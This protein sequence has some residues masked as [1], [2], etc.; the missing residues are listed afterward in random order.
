M[1]NPENEV[2]VKP[3]K[4]WNLLFG[5]YLLSLGFILVLMQYLVSGTQVLQTPHWLFNIGLAATLL[6]GY[7]VMRHYARPSAELARNPQ[8]A[9]TPLA[10]LCSI[11]ELPGILGA[12]MI[13]FALSPLEGGILMTASLLLMLLLRPRAG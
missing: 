2:D 9:L 7:L 12:I 1:N 3:R 8:K 11:A 10:G 13:G 6:A 4:L 5:M